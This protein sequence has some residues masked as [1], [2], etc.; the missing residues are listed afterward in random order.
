MKRAI[1]VLLL[2]S[3]YSISAANPW[4]EIPVVYRELAER[5]SRDGFDAEYLSKLLSD[6][7][8]ECT[9]A[10]PN[11]SA[12]SRETPELYSRF[13]TP[14]TIRVSKR[15]L[16]DNVKSFRK[17]ERAF[18]VEKEVVTA[19]LLVESG[20]GENTGAHRVIPTLAGMV[21]MDS[22]ENLQK[23]HE[24]LSQ[25]DPD[26]NY[27]QLERI[28]KRKANW[29]YDELKSFL[30]I[31]RK[32]RL[33][34]LEVRGSHAGALGM[35]QFL[36][37]SYLA[38]ASNPRSFERWLLGKEEAI[39]SVANYLKANGWRRKLSL[40]G[41]KKVIWSYNRS[42]PYVETILEVAQRIRSKG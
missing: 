22:A 42:R 35:A 34:A 32:E 11:P 31:V 9:P 10:L 14:E 1:S 28:V 20:F 15:F 3:F 27:E 17:M 26:L 4:S 37:S 19:I 40:E 24:V 13:L 8:A 39:L 33:D 25:I 29:A 23:S 41:K 18:G 16:R 36:P 7:R 21:L 12:G 30:E 5:L 2:I 6:P 38:Y